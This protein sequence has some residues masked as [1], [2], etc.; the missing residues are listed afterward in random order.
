MERMKRYAVPLIVGMT[1]SLMSCRDSTVV[2]YVY[3]GDD[4]EYPTDSGPDTA[5]VDSVPFDTAGLDTAETDTPDV[6]SWDSD[7]ADSDTADSDTAIPL[8]TNTETEISCGVPSSFQWTSSAPLISPMNGAVSIKDP[9]VVF[10]GEKWM[11]YATEYTTDFTMVYLDFLDWDGAGAALKTPVSV[12]PNLTGY[13]CAPQLFYFSP[14]NLWYLIYQTQEPSYSTSADPSDVSSWSPMTTFMP[15]PE[16]IVNSDTGGIDYWIICDNTDCYMFFSADNGVLYRAR[17][18]KSDFPNGFEGT[19]EIVMQDD[20]ED[21][22]N[23][24]NVYRLADTGTY[25]LLV[26][27][28]G[29]SGDYFRSWTSDR[30]DGAWTALQDEEMNPFASTFNVTGADWSQSGIGHGE[31][32]R[33]NPD[34][35]MTIDPCHMQFIY[36]GMT[37]AGTEY[38]TNEYSLA[39]LTSVE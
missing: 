18:S 20:R 25:L 17:T 8:D 29:E 26:L 19:T 32:L 1:A 4:S 22:Y 16:I 13:K 3:L 11:I 30:L 10:D 35:T 24:S 5:D 7:T 28:M 37:K 39:L 23:A 6:D 14:E 27:A 9:T 2:A 34:E 36:Q 15:M 21:L 38:N 12:N 33:T 31:M